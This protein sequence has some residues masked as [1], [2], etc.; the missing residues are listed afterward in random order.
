METIVIQPKSQKQQATVEAILKA[1]DVS[2]KTE[3]M[4]SVKIVETKHHFKQATATTRKA[5]AIRPGIL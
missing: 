5:K 4:S 3:E 2:F 1:L